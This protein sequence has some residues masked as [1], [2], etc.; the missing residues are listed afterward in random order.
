MRRLII[1]KRP[2]QRDPTPGWLFVSIG[3]EGAE[4]SLGGVNPWKHEREW[5]RTGEAPIT[6]AHPSYPAERH[7]MHVYELVLPD[8][9]IKF[10]TGEFSNGGWG[11]YEPK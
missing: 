6:V 4:I 7:E 3:F 9:T 11:F 10:A 1:V 8:R 5:R 2:M